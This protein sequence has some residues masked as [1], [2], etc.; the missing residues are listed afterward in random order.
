MVK[1]VHQ[2]PQL[3]KCY[4]FSTKTPASSKAWGK[5]NARLFGNPPS[6]KSSGLSTQQVSEQQV[7]VSIYGAPAGAVWTLLP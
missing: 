5:V 2:S 7:R 6:F 1:R 4:G 3:E